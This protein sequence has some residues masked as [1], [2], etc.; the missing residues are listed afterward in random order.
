[1]PYK[2]PPRVGRLCKEVW[3]CEALLDGEKVQKS[4]NT[5]GEDRIKVQ[6][7]NNELLETTVW[8]KDNE[9]VR[10]DDY[11]EDRCFIDDESSF[12][13]ISSGP[14]YASVHEPCN[15]KNLNEITSSKGF[16]V[17]GSVERVAIDNSSLGGEVK[18]SLNKDQP[19][20]DGPGLVDVPIVSVD[21]LS[22]SM[23]GGKEVEPN[24]Y[25]QG[26]R[27]MCELPYV[28]I[29]N[30]SMLQEIQVE[31]VDEVAYMFDSTQAQSQLSNRAIQLGNR[32]MG[33]SAGLDKRNWWACAA[34]ERGR[35]EK[36]KRA[37][38]LNPVASSKR[39]HVGSQVDFPILL[40]S[41]IPF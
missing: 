1:M 26:G 17:S 29:T 8:V 19:R 20:L 27:T 24:M 6:E 11:E 31:E 41:L 39:L 4:D 22:D 21:D 34:K 36:G 38:K 40:K 2:I 33:L 32:S 12:G 5:F 37:A 23:T 35:T 15:N 25:S 30:E 28:E 7:R 14:F 18:Q 13:H 9:N 3:S 16:H 10:V